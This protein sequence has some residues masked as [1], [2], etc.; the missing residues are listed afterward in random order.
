MWPREAEAALRRIVNIL[1]RKAS[2][3]QKNEITP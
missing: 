2:P 3:V 1:F